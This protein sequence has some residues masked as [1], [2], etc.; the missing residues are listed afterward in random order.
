MKYLHKKDLQG[1]VQVVI[2][3]KEWFYYRPRPSFAIPIGLSS[4]IPH[5]LNLLSH[6]LS[7]YRTLQTEITLLLANISA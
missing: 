1:L 4:L 7:E 6:N 2:F 5:L 3:L